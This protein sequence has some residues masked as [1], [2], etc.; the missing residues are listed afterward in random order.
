MEA[1]VAKIVLSILA[2]TSPEA[3]NLI[4]FWQRKC[5]RQFM[6][7][8]VLLLVAAISVTFGISFIVAPHFFFKLYTG[9]DFLTNS[10]AIDVRTT[11]GGFSFG[12]GVF[13]LL[14]LNKNVQIGLLSS[15]IVL[16]GITFTRM[17]AMGLEGKSNIYMLVFLG[18]EI[19]A[20][21]LAF[22]AWKKKA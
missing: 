1:E 3:N 8:I 5:H 20:L 4:A 6:K 9:S 10:A 15:L 2:E 22:W 16:T 12:Y 7:K 11:Y 14:C 13:L 17:L 18:M 21:V 19:S